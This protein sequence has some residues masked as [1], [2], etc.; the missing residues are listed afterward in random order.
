MVVGRRDSN[1]HLPGVLMTH[2]DLLLTLVGGLALAQPAVG[3]RG[4]VPVRGVVFDSLR[5]APLGNAFV[6]ITGNDRM[7]T[8]DARG[9]FSFDSV[10]PGAHVFTAQHA[11][12]DSIGFSGL[13]ARTTV[14]DG[15]DEIRIVV[16]SFATV[17][18]AAC[19][20]GHVPKDSGIVYGTIRD[21]TNGAPVGDAAVELAWSDLVLDKRRQ[22]MQRRSRIET[23][24]NALGGYA[25]CGVAPDLGLQIHAAGP[26]LGSGTIDLPAISTRVQ[27]RDLFLGP[28]GTSDSKSLGTIAGLV[29]NASGQPFA[30]ARIIVDDLPDVRSDAAG[31]FVINNVLP[32]TRQI[33]VLAIGALPTREIIDVL[34]R[35]TNSVSLAL[36]DVPTLGPVRSTARRGGRVFAAELAERR[37]AGF[38]YIRDSTELVKY[39]QFVTALREIPSL[40]V[41]YRTAIL[42]LGVSNGKGGACT[43]HVVIDGAVAGVPH[44]IDLSPREVGALEVYTRGAHVPARF[45]PP[46]IHLQCGMILVWT[47]YGLRNR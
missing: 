38:G 18:R 43:P 35:D 26:A 11:I 42:T 5:G 13:S 39:D 29:T 15:H 21:A 24:S 6:T 40:I 41:Q 2:R 32:G 1:A 17:W 20:P 44:L 33:E 34:P 12:L 31:R 37:K 23:R 28:S 30:D 47:K 10:L 4:T 9:R 25:I 3:Q 7:I 19:G 16:P 27:R 36:R 14:T 8:T 46:G 22:V 45:V